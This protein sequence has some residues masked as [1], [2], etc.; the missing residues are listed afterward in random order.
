MELFVN[1]LYHILLQMAIFGVFY[2]YFTSFL[3]AKVIP[4]PLALI[5]R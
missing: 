4:W 1:K 2:K 3:V 5:K